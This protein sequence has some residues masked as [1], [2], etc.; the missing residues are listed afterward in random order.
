MTEI[1]ACAY[2]NKWGIEN[3]MSVVSGLHRTKCLPE[4]QH[5]SSNDSCKS[6][7]ELFRFLPLHFLYSGIRFFALLIQR[8]DLLVP[9]STRFY[10]FLSISIDNK[11]NFFLNTHLN[12]FG[13]Q[14]L[15]T[16]L[17]DIL[18]FIV[19]KAIDKIYLLI[20]YNT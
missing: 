10:L 14:I 12:M 16:S 13:K 9:K 19:Q 18:T 5:D 7:Y 4:H 2:I 17:F 20:N 1:S 8:V 11:W 3:R 6:A 15:Q